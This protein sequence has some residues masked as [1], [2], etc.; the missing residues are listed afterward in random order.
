MRSLL[1]FALGVLQPPPAASLPVPSPATPAQERDP[2]EIKAGLLFNFARYCEWPKAA[3]GEPGVF[4]LA[5]IAA[6]PKFARYKAVL[7][8]KRVG[9][10]VIRLSRIQSPLDLRGHHL[11]FLAA[12]HKDLQTEVLDALRR[13]PTLSVGEHPGFA[14]QGGVLNFFLESVD[15]RSQTRF[16]LN[17]KAAGAADIRVTKIARFA[18]RT[19][20]EAK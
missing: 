19:V 11:A 7:D 3:E 6:D 18:A 10:R 1:L 5:M 12:E 17:P 16:E 9:D 20:G 2:D 15:G 8:G 13:E 14:E 4:R